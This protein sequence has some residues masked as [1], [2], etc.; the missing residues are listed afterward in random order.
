MDSNRA[1]ALPHIQL[2]DFE[3]SNIEMR[4]DKNDPIFETEIDHFEYSFSLDKG[5]VD[6]ATDQ[7]FSQLRFDFFVQAKPNLKKR[8]KASARVSLNF[9][10]A[11]E[12][13]ASYL[14][15]SDEGFIMNPELDNYLTNASYHM[16]RGILLLKFANTIFADAAFPITYE[17]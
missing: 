16:A 17:K 3:I 13:L 10:Y 5:V 1:I 15:P 2:A 12:N 4:N 14:S 9:T 6:I 8:R 11:I 7:Q